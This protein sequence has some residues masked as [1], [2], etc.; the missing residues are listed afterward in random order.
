MQ[1]A[2]AIAKT[3]LEGALLGDSTVMITKQ[4]KIK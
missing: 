1:Y 3:Q 4:Q 2:R